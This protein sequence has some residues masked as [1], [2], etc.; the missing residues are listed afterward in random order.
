MVSL[1]KNFAEKMKGRGK[2]FSAEER[3]A[4]L[5]QEQKNISEI[6]ARRAALETGTP[7][8]KLAE[9]E[10][11]Y[12]GEL[13]EKQAAQIERFNKYDKI[14]SGRISKG[15]LGTMMFIQQPI[16]TLYKK[17]GVI[18]QPTFR[19]PQARERYGK[20]YYTPEQEGLRYRKTVTGQMQ[21]RKGRP[22]GTYDQR[23]AKFGG[24]YGFRKWQ[25]T[26][27]QIAR[28]EAMRA[29]TVSPQQEQ[30]LSQYAAQ[31]RYQYQNPETKIIPDTAGVVDM[32]K[33]MQD[34]DDACALVA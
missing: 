25:A 19:Y 15:V 34:I 8:Q 10:K 17:S 9:Y 4:L 2:E 23:Y 1:W 33:I 11:Q 20:G 5:K 30:V 24:V 21:G 6:A 29:T 12:K 3:R 26:Q 18:T 31:Q 16:R 28:M 32:R 22:P 7:K 14:R 13:Y 27:N